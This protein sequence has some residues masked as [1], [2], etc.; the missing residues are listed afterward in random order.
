MII[1]LNKQLKHKWRESIH[2]RF[3]CKIFC[4]GWLATQHCYYYLLLLLPIKL[5]WIM[6]IICKCYLREWGMMDLSRI[7]FQMCSKMLYVEFATMN[8]RCQWWSDDDE[9]EML[10]MTMNQRCQWWSW[11]WWIRDVVDDD[12]DDESKSQKGYWCCWVVYRVF[13]NWVDSFSLWDWVW[14]IFHSCVLCIV[15]AEGLQ[16][17]F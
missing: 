10:L 3:Q 1:K 16:C 12:D 2:P 5:E 17:E 8:Q 9:S 4:L 7:L 13:S 14:V 11:W 15:G 6:Y